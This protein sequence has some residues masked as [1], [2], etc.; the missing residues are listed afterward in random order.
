MPRS[1]LFLV[2]LMG[3]SGCTGWAR[4][5][6]PGPANPPSKDLLEVWSHD[7]RY[8]VDDLRVD[9]DSM[10]GRLRTDRGWKGEFAIAQSEVDSVRTTQRDSV[11]AGLV[12]GVSVLLLY[13]YILR[14]ARGN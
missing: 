5:P 2:S 3:I 11:D 1:L 8:L 4:V 12:I 6:A 9:G 14:A 7:K 10:R 13:V